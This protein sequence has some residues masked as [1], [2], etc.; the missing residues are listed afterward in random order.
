MY[1]I[2]VSAFIFFFFVLD[3]SSVEGCPVC[4]S[5]VELLFLS[6]GKFHRHQ[7]LPAL[8]HPAQRGL[9]VFPGE[10]K[11]KSRQITNFHLVQGAE[12]S[13]TASG[14]AVGQDSNPPK[15]TK[16]HNKT[17]QQNPTAAAAPRPRLRAARPPGG[18]AALAPASGLRRREARPGKAPAPGLL[19]GAAMGFEGGL[20]GARPAPPPMFL[21]CSFFSFLC[22]RLLK[23]VQKSRAYRRVLHFKQQG[24]AVSS[25]SIY[26]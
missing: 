23:L 22:W 10:E 3:Q 5:L 13:P 20:C 8:A 9:C 17:P 15:P 1:S 24:C 7:L 21:T 12:R 25:F 4:P 18:A 6:L 14:S 26:F 11:E 2:I 16:P 19:R